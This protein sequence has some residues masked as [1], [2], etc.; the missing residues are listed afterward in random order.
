MNNNNCKKILSIH[1][2]FSLGGV[3]KYAVLL[4]QVGRYKSI[5]IKS[6]CILGKDWNKDQVSMDQLDID[7]I[8]ISSKLD[9]SSISK[10]AEYIKREKPDAIITHG[11]NAHIIY[12]L[13]S[14]RVDSNIQWLASYHGEY[15]GNSR[16]R[17]LAGVFFNYLTVYLFKHH[18]D[19]IVSVAGYSKNHLVDH[20]V[21]PGKVTV[22]HNG[23][24]ENYET[25][26]SRLVTRNQWGLETDDLAFGVISRLDPVKGIEYLIRAFAMIHDKYSN[27][28]LVI[29]GTGFITDQLKALVSDLGLSDVTTFAGYRSDVDNCYDALDVFVLP[30]LAEYHSIALL[31]AMRATKPIISTD[32]G[33]N[34]E[35]VRDGKEAIVVP[36]KDAQALASALDRIL[37]DKA[38]RLEL[39]SNAHKRFL[40]EFT[41]ETM[42]KRTADW[43][44]DAVNGPRDSV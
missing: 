35:S 30:S 28:K 27:A 42:I 21:S 31:E 33:G 36:S 26:Q 29:I 9:I 32:V 38:L 39:S 14:K 22:I 10:L 7:T 6:V 13:A 25:S 11:F 41:S 1:W 15:H 5:K 37:G 18:V 34:T 12:W 44:D 19:K 4:E 23:I 17:R 40:N 20:G 3:A 2:G 24:P 43:L 16:I 8:S